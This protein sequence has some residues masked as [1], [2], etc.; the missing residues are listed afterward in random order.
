MTDWVQFLYPFTTLQTLC[1]LGSIP[2]CVAPALESV[3][4]EMADELLP[5]LDPLYLND[6]LVSFVSEFC[7]VRCSL[8]VQ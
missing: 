8:A 5:A 6:C 3:D 1:L 7:A 2:R 4:K